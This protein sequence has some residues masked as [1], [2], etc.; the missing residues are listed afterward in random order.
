MKFVN[1]SETMLEI[2]SPENPMDVYKFLESIGR[3]CYKSE[4]LIT[5]D[6]ALKYL[7]TIKNRKH[8][9]MLEHYIFTISINALQYDMIVNATRM[10][11]N[12][13]NFHNKL[14]YIDVTHWK[15]APDPRF[16]YLVSGSATAFNY[17]WECDAIKHGENH[18]ILHICEGLFAKYPYIMKRGWDYD[19]VVDQ[20]LDI[21]SRNEV[22][23][24]PQHLRMIHD[25]MSARYITN[26]AVSHD[27]VRS[28]PVSYAMEST[29][30]INYSKKCG[31][32]YTIPLWFT[33]EERDFLLSCDED[34]INN[35]INGQCTP[36]ELSEETLDWVKHL[37]ETENTYQHFSHD[38]G[39]KN[40]QCSLICP[41]N[42]KTELVMTAR[43]AEW[44][45]F[46]FLRVDTVVRPD[47]RAIIVPLFKE[48]YDKMPE[49][50][51]D[52][53]ERYE[54]VIKFD[55]EI[56]AQGK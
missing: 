15:D 2:P 47:M 29:R 27:I 32:S 42:F 55:D 3:T 17:L 14:K 40:D 46:F 24:L 22:T 26:L 21:L 44:K 12:D 4:D 35:I 37:K 10:S 13:Y 50:F 31:Y 25:F 49:I 16:K 51:E 20:E 52:Q 45:H 41:K 38:L 19:V 48:A 1:A 18:G 56:S 11:P 39:Y 43:L 34:G 23:S 8:W 9:A 5:E 33:K 6:S 54:E 30:W 28:R 53:L 36:F 7:N